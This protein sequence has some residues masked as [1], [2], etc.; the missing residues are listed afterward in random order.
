MPNITAETVVSFPRDYVYSLC[1]DPAQLPAIVPNFI[2]SCTVESAGPGGD[3][4][5]L[6]T[7]VDAIPKI[8]LKAAQALVGDVSSMRTRVT[9]KKNEE[10]LIERIEGPFKS[11]SVRLAFSDAAGGK[12]KIS[13]NV[14]FDAGGF[15]V[16]N[17]QLMKLFNENSDDLLKDV[18]RKIQE[19][20]A[21]GDLKLPPPSV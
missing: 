3:V 13:A 1:E 11:F 21:S 16:A 5:K 19:A 2:K 4:V 14:E 6:V 12:T 15:G 17:K 8:K 20:I 9:R 10:V 18:D 7:N